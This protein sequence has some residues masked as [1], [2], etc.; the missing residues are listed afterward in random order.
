VNRIV[1]AIGPIIFVKFLTQAGGLDPH[2]GIHNGVKRLRTIENLQGDLVAL[3]LVTAPSQ[4]F[5]DEVLEEPLP[6]MRLLEW[7][8]MDD[9]VQFLANGSLIGFAPAIEGACRHVPTPNVPRERQPRQN[10]GSFILLHTRTSGYDLSR[11]RFDDQKRSADMKTL[12]AIALAAATL[13]IGTVTLAPI[14]TTAVAGGGGP[15]KWCGAAVCPPKLQ[16]SGMH[17]GQ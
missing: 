13:T 16:Q 7:A 12:L 8:T 4:S 15:D 1:S 11:F 2:D 10:R 3:Q 5:I 6:A 17:R 14:S 9:A